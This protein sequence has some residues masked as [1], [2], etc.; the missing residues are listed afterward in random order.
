MERKLSGA[1]IGYVDAHLLAAIVLPP[2]TLLWTRDKR[3]NA[4]AQRLSLAAN[5]RD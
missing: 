3:L 1:G 5:F 4:A 2:E